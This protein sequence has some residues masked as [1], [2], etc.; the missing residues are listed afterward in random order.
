MAAEEGR[1][2][3]VIPQFYEMVQDLDPFLRISSYRKVV[4]E[5]KLHPGIVL[6]SFTVSVQVFLAVKD[7]QLVQQATIVYELTPIITPAGF[8]AAN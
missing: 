1:G 5:Q 3:I 7:E 6:D 8:H 2:P 4:Y